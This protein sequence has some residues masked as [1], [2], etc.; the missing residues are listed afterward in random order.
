MARNE[1]DRED[2]MSEAV[3]LIRRIECES[4]LHREKLVVGINS[5]GWLFFYIGNERMYRFDEHFR[6]RRAFVDGLLFRTAGSA[7]SSLKRCRSLPE[8]ETGEI[9]ITTL[10]RRDLSPDELKAFRQKT[11]GELKAVAEAVRTGKVIRQ[12]PAEA[13]G[14]VEEIQ[15][16]IRQILESNEF[17]APAIVRR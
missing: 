4:A 5:F 16:G 8:C 9:P 13:T 12:F 3:S 7:L 17:L 10:V 14:I 1:S 6:L 2:L 11:H 15:Y